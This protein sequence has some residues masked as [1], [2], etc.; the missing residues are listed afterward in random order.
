MKLMEPR[1]KRR[2]AAVAGNGN[3]I[4]G[5]DS[6]SHEFRFPITLPFSPPLLAAF[7]CRDAALHCSHSG[8]HPRHRAE[9]SNDSAV[10]RAHRALRLSD[11]AVNLSHRSARPNRRAVRLSHSAISFNRPAVPPD[12][13]AVHLNRPATPFSSVNAHFAFRCPLPNTSI[14]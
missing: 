3:T 5:I 14:S 9:H 1:V 11:A 10:P 6:F 4:R 2:E 7:L 12:H 8:T 13:S